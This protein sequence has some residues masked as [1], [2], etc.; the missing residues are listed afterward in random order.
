[1]RFWFAVSVA[2]CN[3]AGQD[4]AFALTNVKKTKK[5]VVEFFS[6]AFEIRSST[7][8]GGHLPLFRDP[9]RHA[10]PSGDWNR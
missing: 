1:M 6:E 7:E 5:A 3:V 4:V 9:N 8:I 2:V 10:M